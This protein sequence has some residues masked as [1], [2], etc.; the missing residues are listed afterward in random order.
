MTNKEKM[1]AVIRSLDDSASIEEAIER[2]EL[3][4]DDD[5]TS[6]EEIARTLA[7]MDQ[8][9]PLEMT[10]EELAAWEAERQARKEWEKAHFFEQAEKLRR[11]WE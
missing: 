8:V 5:E 2:L 10:E 3:L 9:E 7:T 4:R 1:L 11:M 6:P